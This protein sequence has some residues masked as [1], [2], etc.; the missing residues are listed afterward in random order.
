M[1][2]PART[3]LLLPALLLAYLLLPA[4]PAH[5]AEK[6]VLGD[7]VVGEGEIA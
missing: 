7:V 2:F 5:A 4:V 1:R 3:I 6:K